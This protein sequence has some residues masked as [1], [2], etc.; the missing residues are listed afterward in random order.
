MTVATLSDWLD[1]LQGVRKSGSSYKALCPAP[2]RQEPVSQRQG[3]GRRQ[4]T[5]DLFRRLH[6][7]GHPGRPMAPGYGHR[8]QDTHTAT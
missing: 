8:S 4:G 6:V 3:G 5:R 1:R 7:R 2:R